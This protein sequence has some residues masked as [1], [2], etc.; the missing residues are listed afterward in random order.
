M[1][2]GFVC[3]FCFAFFFWVSS[4]SSHRCIRRPG[5]SMGSSSDSF[6]TTSLKYQDLAARGAIR[7]WQPGVWRR[8]P[9]LGIS[10]LSLAIAAI[11]AAVVILIISDGQEVSAWLIQPTVL[12]AIV[13][14][15]G[16]AA[17]AFTQDEGAIISWWTS[18]LQ[19]TTLARLHANWETGSSLWAAL[20]A[21]PHQYGSWVSWA[22]ISVAVCLTIGPLLQRATS[23]TAVSLSS[24]LEL[25]I[26]AATTNTSLHF[27]EISTA[28]EGVIITPELRAVIQDH[29][30][31]RPIIIAN[32]NCNGKCFGSFQSIG[33]VGG[34][35]TAKEPRD[36]ARERAALE[37]QSRNSSDPRFVATFL[38]VTFDKS[39]RSYHITNRPDS[40]PQTGYM[41]QFNVTFFTADDNPAR[42][43]SR[44]GFTG[45]FSADNITSYA[46]GCPGIL[47]TTS[48]GFN[49]ATVDYDIQ[50][51]NGTLSML[52]QPPSSTRPS[53]ASVNAS[54]TFLTIPIPEVL[55]PGAP[56]ANTRVNGL[57]RIFSQLFSTSFIFRELGTTT[58]NFTDVTFEWTPSLLGNAY[59]QDMLLISSL[60]CNITSHD[61][62]DGII[63]SITD[64]LFR[65]GI[66]GGEV[67]PFQRQTIRATQQRDT[68]VFETNYTFVYVSALIATVAVLVTGMTFWGYWRLG[69]RVTLSPVETARAIDGRLF[70]ETGSNEEVEG[71]L[72]AAGKSV[73]M[74]GVDNECRAE[75]VGG[76]TLGMAEGVRSIERGEKLR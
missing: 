6:P 74:Y 43:M 72:M 59:S 38:N 26:P 49:F 50:I 39:R 64:I 76:L 4:I 31:S 63:S 52:S 19:G 37:S 1:V 21:L 24:P 40:I 16:T 29:Q 57:L 22:R 34:C 25:S 62:T 61:P 18:A 65:L 10:S 36:W 70:V 17:L 42:N 51:A 32:T 45:R 69:R 44:F 13:S 67:A 8:F 33:L 27:G 28:G 12:L 56:L 2:T 54:E 47:H 11:V 30:F 20:T 60:F 55:T 9:I 46:D 53:S 48:C 5:A 3:F 41:L 23:V 75:G 15:V 58:K 68:L 73:V 35:Q 14:A 7:P 66:R 71:L